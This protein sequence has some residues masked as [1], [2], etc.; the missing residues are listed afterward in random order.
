MGCLWTSEAVYHICY[1][2]RAALLKLTLCTTAVVRA[3]LAA[4]YKGHCKHIA[5]HYKLAG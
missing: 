4:R 5:A 2:R 3:S 1:V